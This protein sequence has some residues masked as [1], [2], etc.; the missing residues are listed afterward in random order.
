MKV[1]TPFPAQLTVDAPTSADRCQKGL[2]LSVLTRE[3]PFFSFWV[4]TR[5]R[6]GIA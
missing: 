6:L 3:D 1:E 2:R 5:R 4:V